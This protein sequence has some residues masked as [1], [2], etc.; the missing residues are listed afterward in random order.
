MWAYWAE[1]R[2][3]HFWACPMSVAN[4]EHHSIYDYNIPFT[5]LNRINAICDENTMMWPPRDIYWK[6]MQYSEHTTLLKPFYTFSIFLSVK[7]FGRFL[8]PAEGARLINPRLNLFQLF[9]RM[10]SV[11]SKVCSVLSIID[12]K[13]LGTDFSGLN[14]FHSPCMFWEIW[15]TLT[16]N[17]IQPFRDKETCI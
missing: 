2:E 16:S 12:L 6:I 14:V 15:N 5:L 11:W 13:H 17:I 1:L 8:C 4:G 10:C 3:F 9:C 7:T